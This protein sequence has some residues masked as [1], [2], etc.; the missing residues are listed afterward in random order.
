MARMAVVVQLA[1]GIEAKKKG[2]EF[3]ALFANSDAF[4]C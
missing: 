3:R 2:L 1:L 4:I